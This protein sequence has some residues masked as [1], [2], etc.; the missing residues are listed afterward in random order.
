M[1]DSPDHIIRYQDPFGR[2]REAR[3][4]E[5]SADAAPTVAQ[6]RAER[7]GLKDH[8]GER[9]ARL[10]RPV[11]SGSVEAYDSLDNEILAGVRLARLYRNQSYPPEVTELLGYEAHS[12]DPFALVAPLRGEP[13]GDRPKLTSQQVLPFQRSLLRAVLTINGAG[14]AHRG[15]SPRTV[16]W[17]G[18]HVQL[19]D[20]STATLIGSPRTA[21]GAQP[22]Q[23]PEQR[24]G[25]AK[26][27]VT[28][29]D[30]LW[31]AARLLFF[32]ETEGGELESENKKAQFAE[33][34]DLAE[35]I[36][37]VFRSPED[38]PT[39]RTMLHRF[40]APGSVP[41]LVPDQTF[42]RGKAAFEQQRARNHPPV[43]VLE[44]PQPAPAAVRQV[45]REPVSGDSPASVLTMLRERL[46]I[47]LILALMVAILIAFVAVA[48]AV[49]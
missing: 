9:E 44:P 2:A 49:K 22:W 8:E 13:V 25:K 43:A 23:A 12:A 29:K 1:T 47:P 42:E 24:P 36:R 10:I 5:L 20:F 46:N 48:L 17:D 37:D 38:R 19:T 15:I 16:R 21:V 27:V 18:I 45:V 7:V 26:G 34:P 4:T 40:G 11:G 35:L 28:D 31:A 33:Y 6:L 30:D 32:V 39:T 14:V 3:L 41:Q